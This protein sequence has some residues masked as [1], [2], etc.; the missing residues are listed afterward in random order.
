MGTQEGLY[1]QL[2]DIASDLPGYDWVG[3]GRDDGRRKGEFMA[4][5]YRKS[6]LQPMETNHFWLSDTPE[7]AGSTTWGN[8]NRRM[9]TR[10]KFLDLITKKEFQLLN[11]HFDHEVQA[12]REKSA[13]LVRK[14][15][16]TLPAGMPLLLIG[17]F[18]AAAGSNRA[19]RQL[20]DDGFL[21][22]TWGLAKERVNEG[23]GTF[24]NF[25][26]VPQN[27][28]RI[29]WILLRGRAVVDRE[30]I[31]TFSRDGRFPSDHC[32]VMAVL[33]LE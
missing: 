31:L 32:P 6:R 14:R 12:A 26:A 7:M 33:H 27:V 4:V 20:T 18:N 19:Y 29:D 15:I 16:E 5:F 30:E 10:I 22:D 21:S 3:V 9:V 1:Q 8:Q 28:Q 23:C 17:D 2:Q 11:T 13:A 24:N 25:K